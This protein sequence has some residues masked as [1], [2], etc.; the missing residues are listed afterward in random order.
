[1]E[2]LD[3][4]MLKEAPWMY[5][6]ICVELLLTT[7]ADLQERV[8]YFSAVSISRWRAQFTKSWFIAYLLTI[9]SRVYD[10]GPKW[11][12]LTFLKSEMLP[13]CI[14]MTGKEQYVQG[15]AHSLQVIYLENK[16]GCLL[17]P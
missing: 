6:D 16:T 14:N 2:M 10:N 13:Q 1:M 5:C 15:S 11:Q 17:F 9:T 4:R 8:W 7:T 12:V 3:H